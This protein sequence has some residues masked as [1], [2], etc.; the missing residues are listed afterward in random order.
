MMKLIGRLIALAS[1]AMMLATFAG[2]VAAAIARRREPPDA[3]PD[4][5]EIRLSAILAPVLFE[6]TAT[7]LRGGTIDMIYGGGVIDL[8]KAVLDPAGAD[9]HIRAI[10]GG[11]QLVVPDEWVIE[12]HLRG[13]GGLG[14]A[15][16]AVERPADAP[17]LRIE[18]F[19][20]L[21]GF[22]VTS[23]VSDKTLTELRSAID[24]QA[25]WRR[26]AAAQPIPEAG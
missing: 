8:R 3:A 15:R 21:G 14:D 9:L 13:I 19:T 16:G 2:A 20:L 11:A 1:G 25:V 24:R 7:A 4:A 10:L 18:G 6:S 17:V 22:G 12:S 23:T 26:V 5:D